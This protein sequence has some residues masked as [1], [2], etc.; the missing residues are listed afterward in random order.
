MCREPGSVWQTPGSVTQVGS[1]S[2][3]RRGAHGDSGSPASSTGASPPWSM[4]SSARAPTRAHSGD[5]PESEPRRERS[6]AAAPAGRMAAVGALV[7]GRGKQ[8]PRRDSTRELKPGAPESSAA[9]STRM[10]GGAGGDPWRPRTSGSA[11]SPDS[12]DRCRLISPGAS[13]ARWLCGD[14]EERSLPRR[15]GDRAWGAAAESWPMS[16]SAPGPASASPPAAWLGEPDQKGPCP[17]LPDGVPAVSSHWEPVRGLA[18]LPCAAAP[19]DA[20]CLFLEKTWMPVEMRASR[21]CPCDSTCT[22]RWKRLF[23]KE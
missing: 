20:R 22:R 17:A 14:I 11:R 21:I 1:A 3:G 2:A 16:S 5:A 6:A 12:P 8:L 19:R 18:A 15:L 23:E 4:V 10:V 13:M 9:A 7:R